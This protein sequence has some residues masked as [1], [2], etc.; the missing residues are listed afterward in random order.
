MSR[1][2][3]KKIKI[4]GN[5]V[6]VGQPKKGV[7]HTP[8]VLKIEKI[9]KLI[10]DSKAEWV[11]FINQ[12][13]YKIEKLRQA[14]IRNLPEVARTNKMIYKAILNY[15]RQNEFFLNIGGDHSIASSTLTALN[16]VHE[17]NLSV[18][19]I[20]AHGDFNT[21]L[22]SPSGNYHGMPLAHALGL[23][24]E[25]EHFEWGQ[26]FLNIE[27]I[28]MIGN[29][30]LDPEEK[31]LMDSSKLLYFPMT[32]VHKQGMESIMDEIFAKID[33]NSNRM[34]HLSLDVDGFDPSLFPGTGT[35][36]PGGLDFEDYSVIIQRLRK[37]NKR[38]V[39]MDLVEV[40]LEIERNITL[41]N[42]KELIKQTF[43]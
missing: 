17:G 1:F 14:P 13:P 27:N 22:T 36:V 4:L 40:N 23:F 10:D 15:A 30:D 42:V 32:Q 3:N 37:I 35:A 41:M 5:A 18:I 33:P 20:D 12:P 39:S 43:H 19:W 21:P 25:P 11:D 24:R 26:Q 34:I 29:R 28:A 38:F 2:V 9:E 16:K 8:A 6:S 7:E 31:M